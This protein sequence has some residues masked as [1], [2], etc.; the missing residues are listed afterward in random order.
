MKAIKLIIIAV[1]LVSILGCE[2]INTARQERIERIKQQE[3]SKIVTY[4]RP[5][6]KPVASEDGMEIKSEHYILTFGK[7]LVKEKGFDTAKERTAKGISYLTF[8][9]GQY[10]FVKG[11]FGFEPK[12]KIHVLL[13]KKYKGTTHVAQTIAQYNTVF[14][15]DRWEKKVRGIDIVFSL[16]TFKHVDIR[17]HEITHA[18]AMPYLLPVWFDEGLAVLVQVEYAK[19]GG[20]SKLDIYH[21]IKLDLNGV[22]AV[23][24]WRGE[25]SVISE[26]SGYGYDY[27]YSVVSELR[28]KYGDKFFKT[29]FRDIKDDNLYSKL[30]GRMG[31]SMLVYYMSQAAGED[32]VPFFKKLM[33]TV[34]KL[35]RSQIEAILNSN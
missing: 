26:L 18:F 12:Y 8:M 21:D 6:L 14:E 33:F 7:D 10:E 17:A 16:D 13:H 22:N 19:G 29:L 35:N 5:A 31:T 32:L 25:G 30:P 28:K 1:L 15:G 20:H 3:E 27:S 2:A 24:Y 4:E 11:I 23:Q 34:R 9:E